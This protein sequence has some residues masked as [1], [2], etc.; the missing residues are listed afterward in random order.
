MNPPIREQLRQI[1]VD[2]LTALAFSLA[3][4]RDRAKNHHFL[5]LEAVL[6]EAIWEI[7]DT[8]EALQ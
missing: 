4:S 1:R 8:L 2:W 7:T 5:D 3:E 6:D